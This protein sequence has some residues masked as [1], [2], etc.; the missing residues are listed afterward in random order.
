MVCSEDV[1][2]SRLGVLGVPLIM[3]PNNIYD[4]YSPADN[5]AIFSG[6][7]PQQLILSHELDNVPHA[8]A[9]ILRHML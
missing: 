6:H 5:D 9:T 3:V 2:R 7:E 1:F 4:R 8:G